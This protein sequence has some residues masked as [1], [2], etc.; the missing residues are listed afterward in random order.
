MSKRNCITTGIHLT[1][2][3]CTKCKIKLIFKNF[4]NYLCHN[5]AKAVHTCVRTLR[6]LFLLLLGFK[7]GSSKLQISIILCGKS[8]NLDF[9]LS[10]SS[11]ESSG[12]TLFS[13]NLQVFSFASLYSHNHTFCLWILNIFKSPNRLQ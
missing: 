12:F 3:G 10:G 1:G 6:G 2:P 9:M 7:E 11:K 4:W 13:Y 8:L 5:K